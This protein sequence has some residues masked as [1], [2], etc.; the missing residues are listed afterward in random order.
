M[1]E[2]TAIDDRKISA[3][4]LEVKPLGE[5]ALY[6][7]KGHLYAEDTRCKCDSSLA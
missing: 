4:C 2:T 7:S 1:S 3:P 6:P 5:A